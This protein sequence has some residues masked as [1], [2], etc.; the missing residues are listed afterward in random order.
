MANATLDAI[1]TKVRRLTRAPSEAQLTT[2]Q[3][4]EYINTFI[5]YDFPEHLRLFSLR[6]TLTFFTQ[7][8]IDEY[9]SD[10]VAPNPLSNFKNRYITV[11]PPIYI[12]GFPAMFTQSRAEFF[13]IYPKIESIQSIGTEGDGVTTVFNGTIP[14]APFLRNEVLISSID[15]NNNGL[16]ARDIPVAGSSVGNLEDPITGAIIGTVNYVTGVF[17]VT[18]PLAPAAGAAINSQTVPYQPA[19]PQSLLYY[20]NKFQ[21]RPVPDQPYR[22]QMEVYIRPTEFFASNE[23]PDLEQWWQYIAYGAAKKVLEDRMDMES[24]QMIM[25][26]FKQQERLVLRRT[27][28]QYT[29][30]RVATIYTQQS[31]L[32]ASWGWGPNSGGLW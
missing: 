19:L 20:D 24:V 8:Y 3:L 27:I 7:P 12:A 32:G 10:V 26:E 15:N 5:L 4:D 28:V 31:G 18:F 29:N 9:D 25:P 22:V 30:E 23:T 14:S 16:A 11:H 1:R 6:T 2:T 21:L 17:T 13:A